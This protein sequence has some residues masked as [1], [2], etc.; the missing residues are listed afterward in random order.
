M[1]IESQIKDILDDFGSSSPEQ[2][3]AV[4][5]EIIPKFRS[6]LTSEY[7]LEKIKKIQSIDDDAEKK[8]Q[9]KTLLPYFDWYVQGL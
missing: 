1:S 5:T 6:N 9:C 4:L 8:K 7:L 3:F 2:I